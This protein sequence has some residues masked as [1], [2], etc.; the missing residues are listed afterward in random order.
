MHKIWAGREI[1]FVGYTKVYITGKWASDASRRRTSNL[2]LFHHDTLT[3]IKSIAQY[4]Y[5]F[6]HFFRSVLGR[7]VAISSSVSRERFRLLPEF[8][9]AKTAR[10]LRRY[11]ETRLRLYFGAIYHRIDGL[12]LASSKFCQRQLVMKNK[13]AD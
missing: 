11:L 9:H 5:V 13:S 1:C 3:I 2:M 10:P 6:L 7:N 12:L 8:I 4:F